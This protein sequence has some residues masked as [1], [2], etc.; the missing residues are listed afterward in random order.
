MRVEVLCEKFVSCGVDVTVAMFVTEP[1]TGAVT[2]ALIVMMATAGAGSVPRLAVTV[3]LEPTAGPVQLP[4]LVTQETKVVSPGRKMS[5]TEAPV[6][7][8]V[9]LFE[10]VNWNVT[11]P[12]DEAGFGEA[13]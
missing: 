12:P 5:L 6:T 3:P 10:T 7:V 4:W 8:I 9:P 11:T 13:V 2:V 1:P